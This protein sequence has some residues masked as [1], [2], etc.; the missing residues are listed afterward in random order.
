MGLLI[1]V[2]IPTGCRVHGSN[3]L[4]DTRQ[5]LIVADRKDRLAVMKREQFQIEAKHHFAE[6]RDVLGHRPVELLQRG[7]CAPLRP[8]DVAQL[9]RRR[10]VP[11]RSEEP[12]RLKKPRQLQ[13][14]K[15]RDVFAALA[16]R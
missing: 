2:A 3:Q 4:K 15:G 14:P 11:R 12:A 7:L 1:L 10:L 6:T 13:T 9:C 8:L 5:A 16:A